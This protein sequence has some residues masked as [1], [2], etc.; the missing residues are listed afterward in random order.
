MNKNGMYSMNND[1]F[2]P[3][4]ENDEMNNNEIYS[5]P[6]EKACS[7]EFSEGCITKEDQAG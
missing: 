7:A 3:A 1:G 2:D 5:I 6:E 4:E